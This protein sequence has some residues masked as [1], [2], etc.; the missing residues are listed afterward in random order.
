MSPHPV[1]RRETVGRA[2]TAGLLGLALA[3][4]GVV[5]I[6]LPAAAELEQNLGLRWL[7]DA[8]G[9]VPPPR[10]VVVVAID[11][12]SAREL[13]LPPKPSTWP[14]GLHAELVRALAAAGA[15]L[16]AFDLTF[17]TPAVPPAQDEAFAR[18]MRDAGN[19][20]LAESVRRDTLRLQGTDGRSTGSAIIE[21]RLPPVQVLA[22]AA[23]GSAP[24]LLP[25]QDRVDYYWTFVD[26]A[27]ASPTLP[28]LAFHLF[29]N[30]A[31]ESAGRPARSPVAEIRHL[32]FYGPPR[33]IP[34]VSYWKVLD[35]ARGAPA[36][37]ASANAALFTGK[38]VFVGYA[39]ETPSG[40]DRLRDDYRTV[41]S[42]ANGLDLSGVE[43]AATAFANLVD[44][45][46]LEVLPLR[47]ALAIVVG[48]GLLLGLICRV[49]RPIFAALVVATLATAYL[50]VVFTQFVDA[51]WWLP[52]VVPVGVQ[53]PLA[54]FAGVW[55]NYRQTKRE[56]EVIRRAFGL[57]LPSSVVEQL[58]RDLGPTE[59]NRVVFGACLASDAEKYTSL[60][61]R[62]APAALGE[63]M[64]EYYAKLFVPVE[65]SH[66]VVADIVGDSMVAVWA[67]TS[68]GVDV[69]QKACR[70]TLEIADALSELDGDAGERPALR[71]RFGLHCGDMLFGSIGASGHYEYRAVG[72]I[73]NTASRIQGLNKVLG[74]RILASA[75]TVLGL[76]ELV[77]RPVGSF[78]L[79]GKA[80][81]VEVVELLG[82]RV[83]VDL[84]LLP[85][86][87]EFARALE[88][89]RSARWGDA[90]SEF[91]RICAHS[92]L[93]GPARF[94]AA[95]CARLSIEPPAPGWT[96]TIRI[97]TK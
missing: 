44:G 33:T 96:P 32:N 55:L 22:E 70:A 40:Q 47:W 84:D 15:R 81:A 89:F 34:T 2:W 1:R 76:E 62:T 95:H 59:A 66:G 12:Q 63:L 42:Q 30:D 88:L 19:V 56:R 39:A 17:D 83:G 8:R 61:E 50:W 14:R 41:Y 92:P 3:A 68:A 72:D 23:R 54:L 29:A 71:T 45:R 11:E 65:R 16:V 26:D 31:L 24:F 90:A 75:E 91:S 37:A 82:T 74:T 69:R 94:Y 77:V 51:S 43:I 67:R 80:N 52:S 79:P 20:L 78:L 60:A 93:D 86:C 35:V 57:F 64:N 27:Q 46:V 85:R 53:A 25:K 13:E 7:F 10:D 48:W 97:D 18:A 73:V 6:A 38:A 28:V 49:L 58:T 21:R 5:A 36:S 4:L 9:P 87:E